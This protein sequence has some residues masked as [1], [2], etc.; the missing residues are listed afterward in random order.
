MYVIKGHLVG[1]ALLLVE[2]SMCDNGVVNLTARLGKRGL[3]WY[4]HP[5]SKKAKAKMW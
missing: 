1:L 2:A 3:I 4:S 5:N